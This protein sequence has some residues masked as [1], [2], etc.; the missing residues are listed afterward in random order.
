MPQ[1]VPVLEVYTI[2]GGSDIFLGGLKI[3]ALGILLG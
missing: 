2:R 1:G 3:F